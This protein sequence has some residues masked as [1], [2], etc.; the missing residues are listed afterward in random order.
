MQNFKKLIFL[1]TPHE[2]KYA[3]LLLVMLI[4]MAFLEM[5]GVAS[6]LPFIAVLSNPD[7]I[8]TIGL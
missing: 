8:E 2:R 5:A 3:I 4:I 7:L 1:L 6:I